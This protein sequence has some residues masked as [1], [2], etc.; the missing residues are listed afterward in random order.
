[1]LTIGLLAS[2]LPDFDLFYFYLIDDKQTFHHEYWPHIPFYWVALI[3][4]AFYA[5]RKSRYLKIA[6]ISAYT[7]L[8]THLLLDTVTGG[9]LW[10]Y[11]ITYSTYRL[12]EIPNQYSHWILNFTLHWSFLLEILITLTALIKLSQ[13]LSGK[14]KHLDN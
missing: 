8:F 13:H 4:F 2:V 3:P 14:N 6:L 1:M 5:S 7:N 12:I 11:P 10:G 9:I